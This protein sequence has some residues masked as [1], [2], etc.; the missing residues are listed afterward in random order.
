MQN[1]FDLLFPPHQFLQCNLIQCFMK[2]KLKGFLHKMRSR[3]DITG[4]YPIICFAELEVGTDL[5]S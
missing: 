2:H 4:F 1:V 3:R 5:D